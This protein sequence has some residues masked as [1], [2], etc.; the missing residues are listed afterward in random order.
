MEMIAKFYTVL[1]L[2]LCMMPILYLFPGPVLD[3]SLKKR[4]NFFFSVTFS[5]YIFHSAD[6][7]ADRRRLVVFEYDCLGLVGP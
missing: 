4:S 2:S 3:Q 5:L 1:S 6:H 7:N